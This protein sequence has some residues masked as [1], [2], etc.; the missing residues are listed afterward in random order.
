MT[1]QLYQ[2]RFY[3][4][5]QEG[6]FRSAMRML[7]HVLQLL[8]PRSIVDVGC[9]VGTWL[10]AARELGVP[11]VFGVDGDY[12]DRDLLKIPPE[13]FLPVDLTAPFRLNQTF[14]LA[15]SLEVGE[16]LPEPSANDYVESLTRLAPAVLY[17]AAIPRQTGEN[18][19]NE[20]WQIWWVERFARFGFVAL[21]CIRR[22]VWQDSAVEWWYAQNTLLMVRED[23]L[24]LSPRLREEW[25]ASST[26]YSVVHPRAYL[27]RLAA[28]EATRPRGF[29]EWLS[30]GP[31][32][33]GATARRLLRRVT[34][35]EA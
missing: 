30:A 23:H 3:E 26:V 14:D 35:T 27:D 2:R 9:G 29:R 33:T 1:H 25:A 16:H 11:D 17:S 13:R 32:L 20:Q 21:D 6:S 7:P 5:Q 22:R 8:S 4:L 12:V 34:R 24:N 19:L 10:A 18:H 31:A 15:L 28:M